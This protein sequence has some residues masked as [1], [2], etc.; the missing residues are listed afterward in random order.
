[1]NIAIIN[2]QSGVGTTKGYS[3]YALTGWKYWLPHSN[4]PIRDAGKALK[5]ENIDIA[6]I[7]EISEKS[8]R[9]GFTS[10]TSL[11]AK[12]SGLQNQH[13]FSSQTIG[14]FIF[15]E[16][17][18]LLSKYPISNPT[19]HMLH[20]ELMRLALEEATIDIEGKKIT[21]FIAHLA[22]LKKNREIQ[23][24]EI[25]EIIKNRT[26]PIILAGDFN[27]RNPEELDML[28]KQTTLKYRCAIKNFPSW[29]PKYPLDYVFLSG[30]FTKPEYYIS[31]STAFS[32]HAMLVVRTEMK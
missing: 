24:R 19:S 1:M 2:L 11:L 28:L 8:L 30:E 26:G 4:K 27:E 10:Q 18:A 14:K 29:N 20:N 3:H 7:T 6:C 12:N 5:L 23:V 15:Y 31:K 32:D 13:F 9:T 21:V 22:L 17:N 16:G 25:I